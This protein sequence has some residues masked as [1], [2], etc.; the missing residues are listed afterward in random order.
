MKIA[1]LGV[2]AMGSVYAG[3][4]ADSGHDVWAVDVWKEHVDA[5]R[6]SGLR[7]EGASG[8][9]TVKMNATSDASR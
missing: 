6:K 3:L 7:V 4:L 8:D 5:I 2:G 9:R 1:I